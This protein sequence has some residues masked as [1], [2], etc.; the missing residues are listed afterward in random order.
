MFIHKVAIRNFNIDPKSDVA[1]AK[2]AEHHLNFTSSDDAVAFCRRYD[3]TSPM[4]DSHGT[5]TIGMF[6]IYQLNLFENIEDAFKFTQVV[7]ENV[8]RIHP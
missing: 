5:I 6:T 2:I 3:E 8:K 4:T 1:I 7:Q